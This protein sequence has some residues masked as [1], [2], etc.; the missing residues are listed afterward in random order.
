MSPG[1]WLPTHTSHQSCT[2][3]CQHHSWR[4]ATGLGMAQ[5]AAHLF[6]VSSAFGVCEQLAAGHSHSAC[7]AVCT[8]GWLEGR[9]HI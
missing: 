7:C 4:S 3:A 9:M 2:A 5:A 8:D 6:L 1:L